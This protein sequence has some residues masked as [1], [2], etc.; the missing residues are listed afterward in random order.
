MSDLNKFLQTS[1]VSERMKLESLVVLH[2]T[3]LSPKGILALGQE[4]VYSPGINSEQTAELQIGESVVA[5]GK[6]IEDSGEFFFE[7]SEVFG[8]SPKTKSDKEEKKQ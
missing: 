5:T 7:V 2:R 4:G 1:P 8:D 3:K 6:I